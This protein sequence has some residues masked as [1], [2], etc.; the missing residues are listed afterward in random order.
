MIMSFRPTSFTEDNNNSKKSTPLEQN[1][2]NTH[3]GFLK[4]HKIKRVGGYFCCS[5]FVPSVPPFCR[6]NWDSKNIWS[7]DVMYNGAMY[8]LLE[9]VTERWECLKL[10]VK[11]EPGYILIMNYKHKD[12]LKTS[13]TCLYSRRCTSLAGALRWSQ[14]SN[15][16]QSNRPVKVSAKDWERSPRGSAVL[17]WLL[18][19]WMTV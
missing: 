5:C 17:I 18:V 2:E 1:K 6:Q 4:K 14:D 3:A 12:G 7:P 9:R 19:N 16:L 13:G 8:R 11:S 15:A 10:P